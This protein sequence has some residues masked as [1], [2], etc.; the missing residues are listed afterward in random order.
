MQACS[1]SSQHLAKAL[2]RTLAAWALLGL[3]SACHAQ[4][5][6]LL[7]TETAAALPLAIALERAALCHPDVRAAA[8]AAGIAAAD[9]QTAGQGANPQLTVGAGSLSRDGLGSGSL[10]RKTFDHQLRID[11]VIERGD[12]PALRLVAA[13]AL[14]QASRADYA[15]ARRQARASTAKLY[16]D[17]AAAQARLKEGSSAAALS[18]ESRQAMERRSRAGDAAPLDAVRFGLDA[19]RAQADLQQAKADVRSAR[20]QLAS[21]IGAEAMG[22]ALVAREDELSPSPRDTGA[23]AE[24]DNPEMQRPDVMAAQARLTAARHARTLAQAQRTRDLSVG[25][26]LSHYP[27]SS[28]NPAGTGDTVSLSVT[29][30]LF[31]RHAYDGEMARAE[32]DLQAADEALRRVRLAA[33]ADIAKARSDLAAT[34]A[35]LTLVN[36]QLLPAAER[37]AAGAELAWR[38]GASSVLDV[39]DARRSLR[40]AHIERIN[41]GAERAK[42]AA[43]LEAALQPLPSSTSP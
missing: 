35:R 19:T 3:A 39:L 32:A 40:A 37:V 13:Q 26:Q 27:V 36:D 24:I 8:A 41:A 5:C 9:V 28:S 21:A 18:E 10:W 16:V 31:V 25:V 14:Q 12:K 15:E 1:S 42:A 4:A 29:M 33:Q 2:A 22:D 7:P 23:A 30:P 17:L 20:L 11:Q 43:Q 38:R 34:Q 6:P